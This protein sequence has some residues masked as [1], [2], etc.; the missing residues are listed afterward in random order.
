MEGVFAVVLAGGRGE[1]LW[2]LARAQRPKAL[3]RLGDKT[4]LQATLERLDAMGFSPERTLVVGGARFAAAMSEE[5]PAAHLV[6]EPDAGDTARAIALAAL[7]ALRLSDNPVLAVI[8]SDH[9]VRDP[10]P[11]AA[12][13]RAAIDV[14]RADRLLVAFGTP[15]LSPSTSYGWLRPA[16]DNAGGCARLAEYVEKPDADQA[17]VMYA[18]GYLW[19]CGSFVFLARVLVQAFERFQPAILAAARAI[20]A[21]RAP[22]AAPSLSIDH[23][24][25]EPAT[26]AGLCA[27]APAR[28]DRVDVGRLEG[29]ASL[30]AADAAGNTIGGD[31]LALESERCVLHSS[32]ATIAA[33]GVSD[34][35]VF[36]ERDVVLVCRRDHA[37]LRRLL[38]ELASR[39]R[40]DLL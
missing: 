24:I 8:P 23:A 10:A 29:F 14:A 38:A 30:L 3:V 31:A 35:L 2:P 13:M 16:A 15:P 4:L 39:R 12:A 19:N 9:V 5:A 27:V 22:P 40:A 1:R 32:D 26:R 21:G 28:Y 20:D 25:L 11:V 17:R 7:V 36:A 34:L 18:S 33:L 6:L 37:D